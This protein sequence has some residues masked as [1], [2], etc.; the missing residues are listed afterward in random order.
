MLPHQSTPVRP[1]PR[2]QA[3]AAGAVQ[4]VSATL[5][6]FCN[7]PHSQLNIRSL[8]V[9]ARLLDE[10][11][12]ALLGAGLLALL[13]G[14]ATPAQHADA[15]AADGGL[16]RTVL[17]GTRFHHVAYLRLGGGEPLF[18]FIDG[19]GTPWTDGGRRVA[20]DPTPRQPLALELAL[21]TRYGSVLYL[22]R[23]CYLGLAASA[24]CH[25][26]DWTVGRYSREVVE[27]LAAAINGF[28]LGHGFREVILV[29]HSGGGALAVLVAPHVAGLR[30]VIAIAPNLD[31][32]AWTAYHGY[33]PLSDS[34]D[35]TDSPPL[36][37]D[38]TEI[39]LAGSVD[40]NVPPALLESYFAGHPTAQLWTLTGFDHR[41]C[42]R[43][44]WPSLLPRV[45]A[46]VAAGQAPRP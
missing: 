25:P 34:L 16:S 27:S 10:R 33:M 3:G 21:D 38:V 22:G 32:K 31:I 23:P 11:Y 45:M 36:A 44:A 7:R 39:V 46:Q 30:A 35:P 13:C 18:L 29:G 28:A 14:C 20:E 5:L 9:L 19:D 37:P 41:C 4:H 15:L 1:S 6:A 40:R 42:W 26:S 17:Q 24:E 12:R 43:E 8:P 2:R